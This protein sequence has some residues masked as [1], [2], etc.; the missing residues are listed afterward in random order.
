MEEITQKEQITVN[1][2]GIPV[3]IAVGV[4]GSYVYD[5]IGGKPAIDRYLNNSWEAT[6]AS[7]RYWYSKLT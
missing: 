5:S 1:G 3:A 7:F 2:G 6:K 4:A